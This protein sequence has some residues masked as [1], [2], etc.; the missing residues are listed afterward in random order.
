[1]SLSRELAMMNDEQLRQALRTLAAKILAE[2]G[3]GKNF[4]N[5]LQPI[6]RTFHRAGWTKEQL[7]KFRRTARYEF[8]KARAEHAPNEAVF[9]A[10]IGVPKHQ[11]GNE[12]APQ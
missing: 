1:M 7:K 8:F 2:G 6:S 4:D 10:E 11:E 5:W 3:S 12:H 9:P